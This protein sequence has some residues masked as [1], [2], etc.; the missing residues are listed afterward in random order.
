M[1]SAEMARKQVAESTFEPMSRWSLF[2]AWQF[3]R[4]EKKIKRAAA[5]GKN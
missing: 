1:F 2:D 5:R 3:K 4:I